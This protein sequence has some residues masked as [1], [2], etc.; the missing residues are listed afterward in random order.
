MPARRSHA[1]RNGD[2]P[3]EPKDHLGASVRRSVAREV[4]A[5]AIKHMGPPER[6]TV[7]R[8]IEEA[9]M[10]YLPELRER[11]N[12]GRHFRMPKGDSG[13]LRRGRPLKIRE[14]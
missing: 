5:A 9:L 12:G 2:G 7:S 3:E 10:R 1:H 14:Q 13:A 11:V 4:R 8:I 6:L